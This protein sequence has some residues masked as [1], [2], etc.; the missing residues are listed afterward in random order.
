MILEEFVQ[1]SLAKDVQL[2][3]TTMMVWISTGSNGGV[4]EMCV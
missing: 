4:V 2:T 3:V 1:S